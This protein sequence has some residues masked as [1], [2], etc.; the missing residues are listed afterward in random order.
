MARNGPR[1]E[2]HQNPVAFNFKKAPDDESVLKL[3]HEVNLY[4]QAGGDPRLLHHQHSE[5]MLSTNVLVSTKVI[6]L[7]AEVQVTNLKLDLPKPKANRKEEKEDE[8]ESE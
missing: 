4:L 8:Q 5:L 7:G 6:D 3:M 2:V 1:I